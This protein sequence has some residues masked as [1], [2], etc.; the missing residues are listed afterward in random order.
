MAAAALEKELIQITGFRPGSPSN[1]A[2][3]GKDGR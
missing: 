3:S 1:R 2:W